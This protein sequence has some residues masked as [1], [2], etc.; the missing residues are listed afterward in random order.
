MGGEEGILPERSEWFRSITL[1]LTACSGD[2]WRDPVE[3]TPLIVCVHACG[4]TDGACHAAND[5]PGRLSRV[6]TDASLARPRPQSCTRR[7]AVPDGGHVQACPYG[8]MA[9]IWY[10]SCRHR[11]CPQCASLQTERWL[12]LQQARL[13]ACDHYHVIFTLPHDLN[14]LWLAYVT[15]M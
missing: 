1:G 6:C 14:P 12:A 3:N 4:G 10:N 9:R 13:L 15:V 7:Y 2:S 8:H 11:A 5:L